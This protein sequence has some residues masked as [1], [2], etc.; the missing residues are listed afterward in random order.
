MDAN[1]S[2]RINLMRIVLI[3]GIVFVHVPHDPQTSPFL[4]TYGFWDWLR[5]FLGD[6]LFRVGVPCL[7]AISGYLLFRR[8]LETFDYGKTLRTKSRT[9][10]LPFLLWNLAFLALVYT[11]QLTNIGFGYLPDVVN[12]G[13]REWLS[14][15]FALEGLPINVPLY[16]LRDLLLCILLSPVLAWLIKRYPL[17]ALG[18]LLAYAVLPLPNGI[19]LKKSI[20]FGFSTGIYLSLHRIDVKRLD[21]YARSITALFL[22]AAVALSIVLYQTGPEFP[23]WVDMLR[24]LT[25]LSGIVG[26]WAV[27]ALLMRTRLGERLARSG[28]LSFWIFCAHYPLLILFWMVW[29][30][31]GFTDY[32]LFYFVIPFITIALLVAAH[33]Y[34]KRLAPGFTAVLTGSR[35]DASRANARPDTGRRTDYSPQQR[36]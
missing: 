12:A 34:A 4:G 21:P 22:A 8:G 25:A 17:Q 23:A 27:S 26:S 6:S 36:T 14:L 35:T 1:I 30:R 9:V 29:N 24:S 15:A 32:R 13:P 3:S 20:L 19:F 5:V 33:A 11:A 16:F 31:T 18:L 2:S 7:S 10:L 28:G